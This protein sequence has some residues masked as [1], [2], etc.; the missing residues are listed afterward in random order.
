MFKWYKR[1]LSSTDNYN[2][3]N[4]CKTL[5]VFY[6]TADILSNKTSEATVTELF[7][8]DRK[9]NTSIVFTTQSYLPVPKNVKLNCKHYLILSIPNKRDFQ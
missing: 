7:I 3:N 5:T 1:Q 6:M 4:N 2:P 9:L 8:C